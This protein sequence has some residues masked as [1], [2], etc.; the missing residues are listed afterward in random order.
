LQRLHTIFCIYDTAPENATQ[1]FEVDIDTRSGYCPD[2]KKYV[3]LLVLLSLLAVSCGEEQPERITISWWHFWTDTNIKPVV[4]QI[5][6]D[7]ES[8]HPDVDVELVDLTWADGHDKIAIAFSSGSGPDIVELGSDWVLEF[9]STGHLFDITDQVSTIQDQYL[10][11]EPAVYEDRIYAFP[12]ILGTRVLF[13]G[14]ELLT[15]AGLDSN[16]SPATWDDLYESSKAISDKRNKIYGFGSNA[17]ERHRLYKKFLP[18]LWSNGGDILSDDGKKCLLDSPEALEA[19]KFYLKLCKTGLT[20]T[21]R[22]LEDAFIEGRIGFVLSGDWLLKRIANEKPDFAYSTHM[23]PVPEPGAPSISFAGGEYL[24]INAK[25]AHPDL[26]L[27][28]IE[29]IC[30]PENQ[31]RFCL[32]NRTANPASV[33]AAGDSVFI[34]QPHFDTF[35]RQLE[36]SRVSPAHAQWVYIEGKLEKAI[37]ASLYG[38][39]SPERALSD[40]KSEIEELLAP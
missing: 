15:R 17:A 26:A 18:F 28:L 12:W 20:D 38:A 34:S 13:S 16:Y 9:S 35:V 6:A 25:S 19:L 36:A 1:K 33:V 5:V 3:V 29:H 22:R 4:E 27:Q 10:M 31:L 37:E 21:Q 40:A 2:M 14:T 11:W 32:R 39:K 23:M 30:S 7:F 8:K 24:A